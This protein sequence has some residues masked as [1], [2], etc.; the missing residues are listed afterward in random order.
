MIRSAKAYV[1]GDAE[2][3][4]LALTAPLSFWGGVEVETGRII[5]VSH[6]QCGES[7]AGRILVMPGAR[8]SSSSSS[9]LAEAI[10]LGTAPR[11]IVLASP[12]PILIVGAIVA[13]SLYELSCPIVVCP[14]D[15]L[16]TGA[17]LRVACAAGSTDA[18]VWAAEV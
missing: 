15:G 18:E 6:P 5:D 8:G 9:V 3:P 4:A 11:G 14:I 16:T 12:D 7:V 2:G 13:R 10:R 17:T 1:A